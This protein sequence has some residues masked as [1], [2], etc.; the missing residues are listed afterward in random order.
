MNTLNQ[1]DL[2]SNHEVVI[3]ETIDSITGA[4]LRA[5]GITFGLAGAQ[6]FGGGT[7]NL[8]LGIEAANNG[9]DVLIIN[10]SF[11][12]AGLAGF[13]ITESSLYDGFSITLTADQSGY[14]F[15]LADII[16]TGSGAT[17]ATVSGSF[18]GTEF[19]DNFGTGYFYTAAQKYDDGDMTIDYSE[20][21]IVIFD[22]SARQQLFLAD[23]DAS[24]E[25]SGSVDANAT[26]ANLDAGT[27]VGSW[28]LPYLAPG[29]IISDGGANNAFMFDQELSVYSDNTV[30]ALFDRS[31]DLM[32]GADLVVEM[33]LYAARQN[34]SKLVEF[35][36][37][38]AAGNSAYTFVFGMPI[39][40]E[41]YTVNSS[42]QTT[43][44]TANGT[45][46]NNGYKNPAVDGYQ[47]WGS[48][49][50]HVKAEITG[51]PT[52][53]GNRGATL[54]IDW[55]GDGDY[56]DAGELVEAHVGPRTS[57]VTT[58][59]SLRIS[60]PVN[61][62]AWIDNLSVTAGWGPMVFSD[63]HIDLAKFQADGKDSQLSSDG[64]Y[65]ATDGMIATDS[66]W[67]SDNTGD[68][69]V[70]LKLAA[71]MTIGSAHVFSGGAGNPAMEDVRL[72][73]HNGSAWQLVPGASVQ[74]NTSIDLNITFDAPITAQQFRIY[75]GDTTARV[76][77][78]ALY[79][80]TSDGSM[81]KFGS[82]LDLNIGKLRQYTYSS[83]SGA[84]YPKLAIDGY[85]HNTSGWKSANTTA[86]HDLAIYLARGDKVG[87]VHVYSGYE[88]QP[89]TQI[90]DFQL[91][92]QNGG[93]WVNFDGGTVTGNTELD[94]I[95]HLN[96]PQYVTAVRIQALDGKQAF[97]REFVVLPD[98]GA[99][100][101]PLGTDAKFEAPSTKSFTDYD[102]AYYTF[103]NRST[104]SNL[105]S[106]TS[107]TSLTADEDPWFQVLLNIGTDTYRLRS[108]ESEK[109]FEV[110]LGSTTAGAA[111]VEGTYKSM[112][113]QRWFL[114]STGD[115]YFQ[116]VNA[117]SGMALDVD[118][119]QVVQQPLSTDQSQHWAINYEKHFSKR[120][121]NSAY[122]FNPL[123]K[124]SWAYKWN[125]TSENEVTYGQSMPMQW[126]NMNSATPGLLT[127][128]T[129]WYSRANQTTVLGFNE[130]DKED[131]SNISETSAAYQW[132]RFERMRLP[133]LSP[134]PAQ[135]NG[136]WRKAYE[137]H[138]H[139]IECD[140]RW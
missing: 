85:A 15:L 101:Y 23:F 96:T 42:G 105:T 52:Q 76:R 57:G 33:D 75:T 134:V 93:G 32:D 100:G 27:S 39:T 102:D 83:V 26:A 65:Y 129:K 30:Y 116:I 63:D 126:G 133:L 55:N 77:E 70:S 22:K 49:M 92:Y 60:N 69:W 12:D 43:G 29:A 88:G 86:T 1:A 6:A 140:N 84:N 19:V 79:P 115:G 47:S 25:I 18:A 127:Y 118:G 10:S 13:D 138:C 14:T 48:T 124:P 40:K 54:S 56:D 110:K 53:A 36:L 103:E 64:Y 38:D 121:Q 91:S 41:F 111:I 89:G 109:C 95:V 90:Q 130:P 51:Q 66:R 31:V 21:S 106:S 128:Q 11:Q 99:A 119:D 139:P 120:G 114:E 50:I 107:G 123:F 94:R 80:P 17:S 5:N 35:S 136:T 78:L 81:V 113:H 117:W 132:P 137:N 8:L 61:G 46:V 131:Q 7:G 67:I 68:H 72:Q 108:K 59:S 34:S 98:N 16:V 37:D 135:W 2:T 112:P 122:H 58:I 9:S 71:P 82:D 20:A 104:G 62:G 73:Y 28:Y 24:T 74:G 125:Y 97:I 44:L 4:S 3:K 87:S 45:G